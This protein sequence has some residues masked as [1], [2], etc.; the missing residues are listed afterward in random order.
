MDSV[1]V[2]INHNPKL[3]DSLEVLKWLFPILI[4]NVNS[5]SIDCGNPKA[6]KTLSRQFMPILF[7][8]ELVAESHDPVGMFVYNFVSHAYS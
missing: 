2:N 6:E 1:G 7:F 8:G 5:C 3:T 4:N